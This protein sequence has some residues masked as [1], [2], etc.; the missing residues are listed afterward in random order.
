MKYLKKLKTSDRISL[1]FSIFNFISLIILLIFINIIYFFIWYNDQK[2]ESLYDVNKNYNFWI[3]KDNKEAFEKYILEKDTIIIKDDWE[4]LCSGWVSKKLHSEPEQLKD[5]YFIKENNK[6]YF[7]F[8]NYY[9]DI[10]RV[11]VLFDTTFYMKSQIIIIKLSF[12]IMFLWWFLYFFIWRKISKYALSD[13]EKIS[14]E[15]KNLSIDNFHKIEVCSTWEN[16]EIK[17]LAN[18]LNNSFDKIKSQT[19][20]LKQFITDVSHEFKTPLMIINSKIDL[21]NKKHEKWKLKKEDLNILLDWIKQ[22]TKKMNKLLETLFLLSRVTEWIEEFKKEK[23]NLSEYLEKFISNFLKSFSSK[24]IQIDYKIEKNIFK[25]IELMIFSIIIENLLTNAIKFS[26][27]NLK[28]EIWLNEKML[29]IKDNWIWMPEEVLKD[30][31]EKFYRKD[32]NVEWFWI[33]LFIVKRI[34][35]LYNWKIEVKSELW[36]WS[37]FIINF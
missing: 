2:K 15:A 8:S 17:I 30:I 1:I 22:D 24:K 5:R 32:F 37:E 6:I 29:Y 26:K 14:K 25:E 13:L 3:N 19:K 18:A 28:L 10:W 31:W 16:D 34:I 12:V 4:I 35:K 33:W 21:F 9:K 27:N 23:I 36:K 7:I 11:K 20:N